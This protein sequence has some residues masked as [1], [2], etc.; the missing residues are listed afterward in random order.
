M[1][2]VRP[3]DFKRSIWRTL[4][5]TFSFR[6]RSSRMELL[7]ALIA[8]V[9]AQPLVNLALGLA[10]LQ[11]RAAYLFGLDFLLSLPFPALLAR[12]MHDSGR[13]GWFVLLA[14]YSFGLNALRSA[15]SLTQGLDGRLQLERLIG[16]LDWLAIAANIVIVVLALW[17]GQPSDNRF[18]PDPRASE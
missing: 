3:I 7:I 12:R 13:S 15:V 18:G 16:P 8:L 1:N 2:G 4:R 9:V 6:G 14:I 10:D 11:P 5:G 17:P